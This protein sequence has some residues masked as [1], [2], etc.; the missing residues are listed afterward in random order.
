[1][2]SPPSADNGFTLDPAEI[3]VDVATSGCFADLKL[4]PIGR[5]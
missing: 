3:I 2:S 1:M 4:T 5:E